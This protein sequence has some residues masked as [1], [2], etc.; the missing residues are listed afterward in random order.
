M[1]AD[2]PEGFCAFY[3]ATVHRAYRL[4]LM[5]TGDPQDAEDLT[6]R[7][8]LRVVADPRASFD[9][10]SLLGAVTVLGRRTRHPEVR[11]AHRGRRGYRR[12][13]RVVGE[14]TAS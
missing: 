2:A 5:F 8:Y 11:R 10:T 14:R 6:R 3:D 4:A 12:G 9:E 13:L 7:A 1:P